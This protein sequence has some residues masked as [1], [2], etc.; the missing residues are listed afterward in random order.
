MPSK[1]ATARL[2]DAPCMQNTGERRVAR[3]LQSHE[4]CSTVAPC[5]EVA[6]CQAYNSLRM[7]TFC[8]RGVAE[9]R[10]LQLKPPAF[11]LVSG[12]GGACLICQAVG[13]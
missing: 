6:C 4:R 7:Q 1:V 8:G 10:A 5:C 3:A 11:H 2:E 13:E 12:G 9:P